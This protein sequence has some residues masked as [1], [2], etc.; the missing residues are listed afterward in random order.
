MRR[1]SVFWKRLNPVS[2]KGDT[3]MP[4]FPLWKSAAARDRGWRIKA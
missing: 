2:G 1:V 4:V 3:R